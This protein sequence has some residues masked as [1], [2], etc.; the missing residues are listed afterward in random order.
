MKESLLNLRSWKQQQFQFVRTTLKVIIEIKITAQHKNQ[1][2][3]K[4]CYLV[5]PS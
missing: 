1:A 3:Q 5:A 2:K 4:K